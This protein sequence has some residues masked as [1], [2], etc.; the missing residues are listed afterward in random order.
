MEHTA[1]VTWHMQHRSRGTYA[2]PQHLIADGCH[3]ALFS[4]V[5][6]SICQY[7]YT[8]E[9][10]YF[11]LGTMK[12]ASLTEW[13]CSIKAILLNAIFLPTKTIEGLCL[14]ML[15]QLKTSRTLWNWWHFNIC[16]TC[17]PYKFEVLSLTFHQIVVIDE[18]MIP[19]HERWTYRQCIKEKPHNTGTFQLLLC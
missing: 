12:I 6:A 16:H 14:T 8:E 13:Q 1:L 15:D 2:E 7:S 4:T 18:M 5:P 11:K 19:F 10:E 3:N 17:L 9:I